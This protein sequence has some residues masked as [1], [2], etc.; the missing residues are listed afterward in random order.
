MKPNETARASALILDG[1]ENY[2]ALQNL[3]VIG[4]AGWSD[5]ESKLREVFEKLDGINR[6]SLSVFTQ[7]LPKLRDA[8]GDAASP[9]IVAKDF[10]GN[11]VLF[12]NWHEAGLGFLKFKRKG[13][14]IIERCGETFHDSVCVVTPDAPSAPV[15]S[16]YLG[17]VRRESDLT[18]ALPV[19]ADKK[20]F[21]FMLSHK[22]TDYRDLALFINNALDD[23]KE[24][25]TKL[26]LSA[27]FFTTKL[28]SEAKKILVAI[29]KA[30]RRAELAAAEKAE[31]LK[32]S[33]RTNI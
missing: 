33:A 24:E 16:E 29:S 12:A 13:V 14:R 18:S 7:N 25:R 9:L 17:W 1:L 31:K 28:P 10:R 2:V 6:N 8:F 19:R 4:H 30:E 15:A 32:L 20:K 26:Q 3:K 11:P 22:N 21:F 5:A 27:D 23:P